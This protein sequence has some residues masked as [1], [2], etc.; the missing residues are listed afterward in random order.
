MTWALLQFD[1]APQLRD[2]QHFLHFALTSEDVN[3]LAYGRMIKQSRD[4]FLLP[5]CNDVI[6]NLEDWAVKVCAHACL[7]ACVRVCTCTHACRFLRTVEAC[8][9]GDPGCVAG[10]PV[11]GCLHACTHA[12]PTCHTHYVWQGNGELCVRGWT[13]PLCGGTML[14]FSS[15]WT[16]LC[17]VVSSFP[18]LTSRFA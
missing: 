17:N 7:R 6:E 16:R 4:E 2:V 3:N 15:L 12:R 18:R 13:L 5:L 1:N 10:S 8:A 9:H 11:R 14:L